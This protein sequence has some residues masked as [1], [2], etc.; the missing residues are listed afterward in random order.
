MLPALPFLLY[1]SPGGQ[2]VPWTC[3]VFP[4]RHD[5]AVKCQ[6]VFRSFLAWEVN[7]VFGL[8][9]SCPHL[10]CTKKQ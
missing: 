4:H 2:S 7:R 9:L 6:V 8:T 10:S 1:P 5:S 3:L